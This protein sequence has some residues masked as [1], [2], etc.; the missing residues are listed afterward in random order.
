MTKCYDA[1]PSYFQTDGN[2]EYDRSQVLSCMHV[3]TPALFLWFHTDAEDHEDGTDDQDVYQWS[4][5]G[6]QMVARAL[7]H[8]LYRLLL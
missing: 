1:V 2:V 4:A 3:V 7:R 8:R 6:L 5:G